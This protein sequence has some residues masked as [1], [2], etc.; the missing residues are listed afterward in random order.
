MVSNSNSPSFLD[1]RFSEMATTGARGRRSGTGPNSQQEEASS[2]NLSDVVRELARE[3]RNDRGSSN[4]P[5]AK[6]PT[7]E[8]FK[9]AGPAFSGD[10]NPEKAERWIVEVERLFKGMKVPT[11]ERVVFATYLFVGEA[12]FWWESAE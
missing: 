11:D 2:Q 9:R 1:C 3:L 12:V 10:D 5:N 4:T 6:P 7:L 8:R